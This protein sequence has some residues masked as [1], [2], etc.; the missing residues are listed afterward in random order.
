VRKGR[1]KEHCLTAKW[2]GKE[3]ESGILKV[4]NSRET[5]KRRV[6]VRRKPVVILKAHSDVGDPRVFG[7]EL[8][9]RGE[10]RR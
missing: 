1:Y 7:M 2:K 8:G 9:V 10:I 5:Y 6:C 4:R 3:R